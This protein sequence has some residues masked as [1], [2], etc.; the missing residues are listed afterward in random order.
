MTALCWLLL[1]MQDSQ[2]IVDDLV[3]V[4][5]VDAALSTHPVVVPVSSSYEIA[6]VFDVITYSKVRRRPAQYKCIFAS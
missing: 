2:F 5:S 6:E 1:L 3:S 4:M